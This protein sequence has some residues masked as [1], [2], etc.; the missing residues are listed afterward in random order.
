MSGWVYFSFLNYAGFGRA[1][2][3][4]QTARRAS[5]EIR[6]ARD[7]IASGMAKRTVVMSLVTWWRQRVTTS[8]DNLP[9]W[10]Y[11]TTERPDERSHRHRHQRVHGV[12]ALQAACGC[13]CRTPRQH[14]DYY[15]GDDIG[16]LRRRR[17][18]C[19]DDILMFYGARA[20]RGPNSAK[21]KFS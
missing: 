18:A 17:L 21:I 14:E 1:L 16:Q 3:N 13:A 4:H 15:Y 8:S 7:V 2:Q 6:R 11:P 10:R 20:T 5:E 19:R 9:L 12:L